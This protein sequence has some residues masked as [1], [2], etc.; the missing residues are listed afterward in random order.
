MRNLA[1]AL[2]SFGFLA[3]GD[4][5]GELPGELSTVELQVLDTNGDVQLAVIA[6][7]AETAEARTIGLGNHEPLT[8]DEGLLLVF[9]SATRV[10][11]WNQPVPFDIDVIFISA[12]R[13]VIAVER[14]LPAGD[15]TVHCHDTTRMVLEVAASVANN[16]SPGDTLPPA[17]PL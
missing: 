13:R 1:L 3:C 16:V 8:S 10:C 14:A 11:I 6:E 12:D 17:N 7:L 5:L 15:S 4:D 2:A 9:P